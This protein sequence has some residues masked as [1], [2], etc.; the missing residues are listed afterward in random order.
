MGMILPP[1]TPQD[2][3]AELIAMRNGTNAYGQWVR[4]DDSLDTLHESNAEADRLWWVDVIRPDGVM[5][6]TCGGGTS[7]AEATA[8]AWITTCLGAWWRHPSLSDE[9]YAKVPRQV[10]EGWYFELY[11]AP[12]MHSLDTSPL[13]RMFR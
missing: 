3:E 12:G 10:P 4:M 11:A 9:D 1:P 2:I 6:D 7:L 13:S 8:V 5:D